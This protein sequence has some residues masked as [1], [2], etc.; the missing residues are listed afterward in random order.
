MATEA[1]PHRSHV[2]ASPELERFYAEVGEFHMR[3]LWLVL[4][5][6]M[7]PEPTPKSVPHVWRWR[8]VEPRITKAGRLVTADQ[9]ERRVLMLLNPALDKPAATAT[10][11]AGIQMVLP[12]EIART[13]HHSPAAI[14]FVIQGEGAHTTVNGEKS[15]MSKG[16]YLTTPNWTWHDHGNESKEP[17]I[18]LDGLDMPFVIMMDAM[19]FQYFP[20]ETQPVTK[21][22]DDSKYRWGANLKP[23]WVRPSD[24]GV[25]SP[26]LN[27]RW[28]DTREVL[29]RLREDEGSPCD[30]ILMEYVNPYTG[31]PSLPTMDAH[32][33]LLRAGEH[34]TAHRHVASTVY[35][36]AEG[37]GYSIINGKRFDWAL[38]DTFVVPAWSWHEHA[39]T[40]GEAVLFSYSD[41]PI[42]RSFG[43][44]R[45]QTHEEKHE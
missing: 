31:G 8:D 44:D 32:L 7:T 19:F 20:E 23:S 4:A 21:R 35:N 17:V 34:T 1:V 25:Y 29:H 39:S 30:G 40:G 22:M 2:G 36:V 28:Q 41:R 10:L 14:R 42:L 11:F 13:H 15:I 27:Y 26:L 38:N 6:A 43:L 16:D 9:A 12:G 18:W 45:E 37:G 5:D 24:G 3:P 33:Q